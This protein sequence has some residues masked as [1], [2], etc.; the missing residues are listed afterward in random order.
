MLGM[1]NVEINIKCLNSF[2]VEQILIL[3][4]VHIEIRSRVDS[5]QDAQNNFK[6]QHTKK[7]N[8]VITKSF[9]TTIKRCYCNCCSSSSLS[10]LQR[11][12]KNAKITTKF[13]IRKCVITRR[14]SLTINLYAAHFTAFFRKKC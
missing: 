1:E 11:I 14:E 12:A 13:L 10:L 6:F 3:Y 9:F 8:W 2:I 5:S 4:L 7:S